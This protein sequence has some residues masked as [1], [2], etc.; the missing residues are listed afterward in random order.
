MGLERRLR[1]IT[2]TM[3]VVTTQLLANSTKLLNSCRHRSD[4]IVKGTSLSC[5]RSPS[6]VV[7][8]FRLFASA[9]KGPPP[10]TIYTVIIHFSSILRATECRWKL[11]DPYRAFRRRILRGYPHP[12]SHRPKGIRSH[13]NIKV[14]FSRW[15]NNIYPLFLPETLLH[16]YYP[17]KQSVVKNRKFSNSNFSH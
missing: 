9:R 10:K 2:M 15:Y 1:Y 13:Y 4:F 12:P 14:P 3:V 6:F 11:C 5:D 16:S 7:F 17:L 8:I